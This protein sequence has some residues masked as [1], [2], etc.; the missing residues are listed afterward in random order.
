MSFRILS[1][2]FLVLEKQGGVRGG[3][4]PDKREHF[5]SPLGMQVEFW[6]LYRALDWPAEISLLEQSP[7]FQS[8]LFLHWEQL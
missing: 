1:Y 3:S 8:W 2:S 4:S 5:I 7:L 6:Q